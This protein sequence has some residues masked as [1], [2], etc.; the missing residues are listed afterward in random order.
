LPAPFSAAIS[1]PLDERARP[2]KRKGLVQ[3]LG[4]LRATIVETLALEDKQ[5]A[6]DLM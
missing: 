6:A 2:T 1:V 4:H 3:E 5:K